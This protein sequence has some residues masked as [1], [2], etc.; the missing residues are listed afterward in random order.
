[1]LHFNDSTKYLMNLKVLLLF[2][3]S[4][5]EYLFQGDVAKFLKRGWEFPEAGISPTNTCQLSVSMNFRVI[6]RSR[7]FIPRQ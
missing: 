4:A 1:M 3:I 5:D 7:R 2:S 6:H